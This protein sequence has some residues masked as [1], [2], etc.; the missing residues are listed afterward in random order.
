MRF[1]YVALLLICISC[2][3]QSPEEHIPRLSGYWEIDQVTL[4]DG[5]V[6]DFQINTLIDYIEVLGDSGTRKKLAPKLDGTFQTTKAAEQF[7]LKIEKDHLH[8]YYKT[9][10]AQWKETVIQS[11][12]SLLTV[13]NEDGN[14]YTYKR[15]KP[16]NL[17][18]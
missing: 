3:R 6:K 12:D 5:T 2:G 13:Q 7:L 14:T 18:L 4:P 17:N 8:L 15:F 1:V 11:S 16:L 10:Y 9:P